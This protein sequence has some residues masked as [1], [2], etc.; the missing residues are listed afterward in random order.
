MSGE[1]DGGSVRQVAAGRSADAQE[2][3]LYARALAA[4]A[5]AYAPYSGF[6]VGAT[7]LGGD[8]AAFDGVNVENACYP[9]GQCAERVALGAFVTAGGRELA[10]VAVASPGADAAPCGAC[11]QALAE[12]GDPR[13]V[14]RLGGEV[15]SAPLSELL[16]LPFALRWGP[17]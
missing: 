9:V 8:G 16:R 4:A 12:F 2:R 17:A 3:E 11:L 15:R 14:C 13:I 7:L 6:A 10:A 1:H 5:R